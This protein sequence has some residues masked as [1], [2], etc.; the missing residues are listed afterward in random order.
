MM[1]G[2]AHAQDERI[3]LVDSDLE[4]EP[5]WLSDF[6]DDMEKTGSDVVYGVQQKRRGGLMEVSTGRLFYKLFRA[7]TGINPPDNMSPLA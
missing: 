6:S 2:L 5:E 7:L 4:E 3:F 1:T